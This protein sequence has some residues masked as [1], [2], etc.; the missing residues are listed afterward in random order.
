MTPRH[1][2]GEVLGVA[3]LAHIG[4]TVSDLERSTAFY[5]DVAGM[6]AVHQQEFRS[7]AFDEL[8]NNP[9]SHIRIALLTA[10]PLTLQ[11]VEYLAGGGEALALEHKNVGTPHFAFWVD[12]VAQLFA[13]LRRNPDVELASKL[14]EIA[15]GITSFYALD[16]DGL[17]VE[18]AERQEG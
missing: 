2:C 8:T 7:D 12:D 17:P 3:E 10:G 9:G 15:P 13:R 5:R 16:P 14:I 4:L 18:F 1:F 6:T 11:L